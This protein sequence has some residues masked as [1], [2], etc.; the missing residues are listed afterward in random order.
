MGES[1][2][3]NLCISYSGANLNGL[4]YISPGLA[5]SSAVDRENAGGGSGPPPAVAAAV[6]ASRWSRRFSCTN[7]AAS[8]SARRRRSVA[9]AAGEGGAAET[10]HAL[11]SLAIGTRI[12]LTAELVANACS[13]I[14]IF[15]KVHYEIEASAETK[16]L[17]KSPHSEAHEAMP[18]E[19][20]GN[21]GADA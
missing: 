1:G 15:G 21:G 8:A 6:P 10:S 17:H 7:A 14:H 13:D 20:E 11:F 4:F 5:R 3:K 12:P 16:G 2:R 18:M 9:A 19:V